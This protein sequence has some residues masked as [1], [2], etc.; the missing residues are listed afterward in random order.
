MDASNFFFL[1]M[2]PAGITFSKTAEKRNSAS[3]TPYFF[4]KN[5]SKWGTVK[6]AL[7]LEVCTSAQNII[8]RD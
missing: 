1:I 7:A 6:S 3:N 2:K 8:G 4:T 5:N